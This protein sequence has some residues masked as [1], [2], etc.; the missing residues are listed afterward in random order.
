[1]K[2]HVLFLFILG[3]M[4]LAPGAQGASAQQPLDQF[5]A[6]ADKGALDLRDA[7]VALD[8]AEWQT[9]EARGRLFPV[10][11]AQGT[12]QR[13]QYSAEFNGPNGKLVI[14]P[15]DALSATF[16]A[17]VP[18]IDVSGWIRLSQLGAT[19]DQSEAHVAAVRDS[20]RATVVTIWHQL[21]ASR[22]LVR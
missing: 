21:V 19:E 12:Y 7:R 13:N 11:S 6:A 8:Q 16:S 15:T 10:L 3:S 2:K 14:Q 9:A 18:I 20:V 4:T 17:T 5:L 1:M 22:A